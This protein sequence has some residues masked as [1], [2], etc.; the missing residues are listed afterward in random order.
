MWLDMKVKK[1]GID[2]RKVKLKNIEK[3]KISTGE[4]L[5]EFLVRLQKQD[6]ESEDGIEKMKVLEAD[7]PPISKV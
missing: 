7:A 3:R 6:D 1:S 4:T 5:A 2:E